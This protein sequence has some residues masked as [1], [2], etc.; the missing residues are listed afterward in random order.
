M[1]SKLKINESAKRLYYQKGWW[2]SDTIPDAWNRVA[3]EHPEKTYVKDD[4]GVSY[5]YASCDEVA[6]RIA[7]WLAAVWASPKREPSC[8]PSR[9][10]TMCATSP[11]S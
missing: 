5:T 9:A 10:T 7:A 4:R 11:S 2:T 8:T 3:R 1:I 6:E